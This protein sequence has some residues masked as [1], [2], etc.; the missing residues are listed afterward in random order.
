MGL[1]WQLWTTRRRQQQA[2]PAARAAAAA[3]VPP[4]IAAARAPLL[5][6]DA[7][8]WANALARG[9]AA[10]IA[11]L[12]CAMAT[13][14]VAD[15]D[16]ARARLTDPAQ[17]AAVDA[18]QRARWGNGDTATAV[19]AVRAAFAAGPRWRTTAA[20]TVPALLPPLYP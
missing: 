8:A 6:A 15:L 5:P 14:V 2:P 9:N 11:R 20:P 10:E 12:L 4:P 16:A 13:P 17:R 1:G 19:A 7:K 3:W 18:L